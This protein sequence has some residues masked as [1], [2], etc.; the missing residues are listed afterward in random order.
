MVTRAVEFAASSAKE[1]SN[2]VGYGL[3][4]AY[5]IVYSGIAVSS[6]YYYSNMQSAHKSERSQK[7]NSNTSCTDWL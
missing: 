5:L 7:H 2:N 1:Q 3:I 4:G 6:G